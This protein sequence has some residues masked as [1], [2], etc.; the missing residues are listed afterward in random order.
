MEYG[1]Q[2]IP[3]TGLTCAGVSS[4]GRRALFRGRCPLYPTDGFASRKQ[5]GS[6]GTCDRQ[7]YF[8]RF[9][10]SSENMQ[11]VSMVGGG[12]EKK[13]QTIMFSTVSK[14]LSFIPTALN[15]T[16]LCLQSL[17]EKKK[18][19]GP[20]DGGVGSNICRSGAS[21]PRSLVT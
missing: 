17:G 12:V 16:R 6:P 11:M 5:G 20:A 15:A 7:N 3:F 8:S 19:E 2:H 9:S 14:Q 21:L 13:T 4:A 10:S 1:S 18:A